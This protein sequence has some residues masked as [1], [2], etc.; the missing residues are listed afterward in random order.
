MALLAKKDSNGVQMRVFQRHI[1][2]LHAMEMR[3]KVLIIGS[4]IVGL[5][6]ASH[7]YKLRLTDIV[8]LRIQQSFKYLTLFSDKSHIPLTGHDEAG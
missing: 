2:H 3:T 6:V 5:S 4:C 1:F 7:F 8:M